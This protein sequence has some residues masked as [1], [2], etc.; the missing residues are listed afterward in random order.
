MCFHTK[1]TTSIKDLE[2]KLKVV[3]NDQFEISDN[4]F[5]HFHLNGYSHPEMLIIPQE[6]PSILNPSNWGLMPRN[7][8]GIKRNDYY[9]KAVKWGG[10][11]NAQSEKMFEHFLYKYSAFE[12]R[13]LIPVDG[14]YEPHTAP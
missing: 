12:R 9:K 6:D 4:D 13:C 11:L 5:Y 10:G 2:E 14:F 7:E 1:T 3:R 8:E